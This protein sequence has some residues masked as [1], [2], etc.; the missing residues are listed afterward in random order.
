MM[1]LLIAQVGCWCSVNF[2]GD[3]V[4]HFGVFLHLLVVHFE[5]FAG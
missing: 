1:D 2:A 3:F 5:S 4:C